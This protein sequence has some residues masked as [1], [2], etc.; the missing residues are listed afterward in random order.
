LFQLPVFRL[1][2]G[3]VRALRLIPA[4]LTLALA[5]A[6][7]AQEPGAAP[8]ADPCAEGR[9]LYRAGRAL[10]ARAALLQCLEVGGPQVETLLPL[11]VIAVRAGNV[12]EAL[13]FGARAAS[14]APDDPE[15]RYWHGRALLRAGR[16]D[17]A[18]AE[19]EAGLQLTFDHPGILEGLARLA[20]QEGQAAKAYNLL[21]QLQRQGVD[22]AW[23][24]GLLAE[25]A[26]SRGLWDQA[27]ANLEQAMARQTP[28]AEQLISASEMSILAG[29][30]DQSVA[31]CRRAVAL[32]PGG[33]TYGALG[34]AFFA[35]ESMD[36]ALVWLRR[37]VDDPAAPPRARFNLANALEV[38]GL[39]LE[40][41]DQF[42][43]FLAAM[44]QDAMG[45]FNYGIHLERMDRPEEGLAEVSRA[46]ELD[47]GMLNA[48]VVKAQMLEN[49]E[50]WDEALAVVGSLGSRDP[51][52]SRELLAWE[53]RLR[54]RRDGADGKLEAGL[55][56]LLHMV[57]GSPEQ[58]DRVQAELE[59][60]ADFAEL[61]VRLS[62]GPAAAKGGD[63]GWIDPAQM[64]E[65]LRS[66]V[67]GL[68]PNEISP[69]VEARGLY[70]IFKR[71]R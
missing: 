65:P 11:T 60:G 20:L 6:A 36:S 25:I 47:P 12:D 40:A 50:R 42:R 26:A 67:A 24:Y 31:Y 46:I 52:A 15:T 39:G 8:A 5:A 14:L 41:G 13:D 2:A 58:V 7:F 69:P 37:A 56:H 71:I 34:E 38:V 62:Q 9:E 43:L 4:V 49:L 51:D 30:H 63:I 55:V 35:A 32:A 29:R 64:A 57:L 1:P 18:R 61:T 21:T 10:E 3:P 68:Q 19:W 66:A 54:D 59:A 23:L 33:R 16:T 28:G 22:D 53:Q 48:Y 17:E 27:L 44:P 70:H 45:H